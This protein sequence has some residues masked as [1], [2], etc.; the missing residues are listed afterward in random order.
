MSD[1][2]PGPL[3]EEQ[4]ETFFREGYIVARALVPE[5]AVDRALEEAKKV[6]PN[7]D[8]SWTPRAFEHKN[9]T[10]DAA[11]HRLL[12]E[13]RVIGAVEQIFEAPARI[14]W[15][16]VAIVS[17]KGGKG[18]AWHQDNQYLHLLGRAVNCFMALCNITPDKAILWVAPR[19]HLMGVQKGEYINGHF[20][21]PDPEGGIALPALNK[22]DVCIFDR[23]TLHRSL[24]N[25][26]SEHRYAYAAQYH[27]AKAREAKSG[28]IDPMYPLAAELRQLY[29]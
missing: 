8:G 17:A 29:L 10:K 15:G 14:T 9:P 13:P 18:L 24:R 3:A 22:G 16:M 7:P 19:S 12:I 6:A 2:T 1:P 26:T 11:Q 21:T 4:I 5:P 25:E 23:S 28:K 20:H 27:E